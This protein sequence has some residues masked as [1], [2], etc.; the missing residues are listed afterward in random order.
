M[1][2]NKGKDTANFQTQVLE[3]EIIIIILSAT[4]FRNI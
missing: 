1:L 3:V 4:Q 2:F